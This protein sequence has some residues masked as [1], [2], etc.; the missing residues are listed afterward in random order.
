VGWFWF[1]VCGGGVCGVVVLFL[2]VGVGLCGVGGVGGVWGVGWV[3][4]FGLVCLLFGVFVGGGWGVFSSFYWVGWTTT[5]HLSIEGTMAAFLDGWDLFLLMK[6][7][8]GP[9]LKG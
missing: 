2:F 7:Y 3:V 4:V 5:L 9:R 1:L 6:I 8:V